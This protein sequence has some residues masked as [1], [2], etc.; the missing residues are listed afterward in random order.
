MISPSL[1]ALLLHI[2]YPVS[3]LLLLRHSA[4]LV[5]LLVLPVARMSLLLV[6]LGIHHVELSV[7][8]FDFIF[9]K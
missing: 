3:C 7:D 6:Q 9:A 8:F 5:V 1:R 2:G 4:L